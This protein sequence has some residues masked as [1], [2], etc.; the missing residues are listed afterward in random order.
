VIHKV[1]ANALV[2]RLMT[3][4]VNLFSNILDTVLAVSA[5]QE[6]G[7]AQEDPDIWFDLLDDEDVSVGVGDLLFG[8]LG[9]VTAHGV[10]E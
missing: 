5:T 9:W 6:L 2:N 1:E 8:L 4:R 7:E 10:N 3:V